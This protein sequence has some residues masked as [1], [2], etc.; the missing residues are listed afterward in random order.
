MSS[1]PDCS[2]HSKQV[3]GISDMK[4]LAENIGDLHYETLAE[5]FHE[6]QEKF[7]RDYQ[8]D[9]KAGYAQLAMCLWDASIDCGSVSLYIKNAWRISKTFMTKPSQP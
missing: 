7:D 5:L 2:R 8:R 4:L 6:L 3:A 1:K 9:S